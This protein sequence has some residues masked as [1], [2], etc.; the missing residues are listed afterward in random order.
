MAWGLGNALGRERKNEMKNELMRLNLQLFADGEADGA[1]G[2]DGGA[3][4]PTFDEIL[5]TP[6]FQAEFDKRVAKALG[7]Q[8]SKLEAEFS[9]R[10][11]EEKTEAAK[12]AKMNEEQKNQYEMD[13]L[14][15]ELAELKA[16]NAAAEL[17]SEAAKMLKDAE[18]DA[19]QDM[20][21]LVVGKDAEATKANV[22]KFVA[23]IQAQLKAAEVKRATGSTPKNY[24]GAKEE[25]SEIQKRIN[26]YK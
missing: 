4:T 17:G 14:K 22:E 9:Q 1:E 21:D 16:K 19:T 10:S 15:E 5:K 6:G 7:T 18:I 2:N 12:L 25:L 20:L 8:K 3:Q 24:G 26:K 13:K 23:V 11:E